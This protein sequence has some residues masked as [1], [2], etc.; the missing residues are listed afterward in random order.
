MRRASSGTKQRSN[1][2]VAVQ[3]RRDGKER[4]LDNKSGNAEYSWRVL[5]MVERQNWRCCLEHYAPMCPGPLKAEH[6]TFEHEHGRGMNGSKRDDRTVL[7]D[8]TWI[9]GAAHAFCNVWKASRYIPYNEE[10]NRRIRE[11]LPP[12]A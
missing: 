10:A 6:A 8:G 2:T 11:A 9:N 5:E 4:C 1:P 7:P 12:T 3:V